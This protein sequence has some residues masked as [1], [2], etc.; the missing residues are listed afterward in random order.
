MASHPKRASASRLSPPVAPRRRSLAPAGARPA[1]SASVSLPA[2][3]QSAC[4]PGSRKPPPLV[5]FARPS[6]AAPRTPIGPACGRPLEHVAAGCCGDDAR[7]H[8]AG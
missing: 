6:S 8:A 2:T 3:K 1:H 5:S 7:N 4:H